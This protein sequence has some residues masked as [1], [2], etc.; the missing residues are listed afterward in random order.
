MQV[1]MSSMIKKK[2]GAK[3]TFTIIKFRKNVDHTP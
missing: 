3:T 1:S 2:C